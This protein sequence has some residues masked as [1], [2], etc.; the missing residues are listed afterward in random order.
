MKRFDFDI[1]VLISDH[2][3]E[4]TVRLRGKFD[5]TK[6][7][8]GEEMLRSV[9]DG[10]TS[11]LAGVIHEDIEGEV[12]EEGVLVVEEATN[13][14]EVSEDTPNTDD[15]DKEADAGTVPEVQDAD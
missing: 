4:N 9:K 2:I 1:V 8:D 12:I 10:V 3:A 7:E 5:S 13:E 14:Q 6:T 15:A 11:A